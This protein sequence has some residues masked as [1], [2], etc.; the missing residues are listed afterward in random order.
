MN[1]LGDG[2]DWILKVK[3]KRF[4]QIVQG[5]LYGFALAGYVNLQ[6]LGYIP[7]AFL[8]DTRGEFPICEIEV[9]HER[10]RSPFVCVERD[11]IIVE[12]NMSI[13]LELPVYAFGEYR[14]A[15]RSMIRFHSGFTALSFQSALQ[16]KSPDAYR[17]SNHSS[18]IGFSDSSK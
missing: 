2:G 4:A 7:F 8:P 17:V 9:I 1:L 11:H 16:Y 13:E 12:V 15:L 3:F 5:S 14:H 18:D 6:S 10:A